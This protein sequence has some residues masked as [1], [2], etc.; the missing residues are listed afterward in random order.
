MPRR[1]HRREGNAL[2]AP[3]R[4]DSRFTGYGY[5]LIDWDDE[6][7]IKPSAVELGDDQGWFFWPPAG[8]PADA[9][10]PV[11]APNAKR[12]M[13]S[14][15][16]GG[17]LGEIVESAGGT[18]PGGVVIT[19]GEPN[20]DL[21]VLPYRDRSMDLD[22]RYEPMLVVDEKP[23][24]APPRESDT[25]IRIIGSK[26]GAPLAAG[27]PGIIASGTEEHSQENLF[28]PV[29]TT[30]IAHWRPGN[31]NW[32]S[33][34]VYD[35]DEKRVD[36]M[37]AG[38]L[39]T[40]MRVTTLLDEGDTIVPSPDYRPPTA[41]AWVGM[42]SVERGWPRTTIDR[43]GRG[44]TCHMSSPTQFGPPEETPPDV[45]LTG[46]DSGLTTVPLPGPAPPSPPGL[47][48]DT[49]PVLPPTKQLPLLAYHS[50]DGGGPLTAGGA[51]CQHQ[52]FTNIDE[53]NFRPG[54]LFTGSL[55]WAGDSYDAPLEFQ[56][57]EYPDP[58]DWP[59]LAKVHLVYDRK[60]THRWYGGDTSDEREGKGLWRW[61][62]EVPL[63]E[64]N[65][66]RIP[67]DRPPVDLPPEYGKPGAPAG[68]GG[69]GAA[70][71]PAG[72]PGGGAGAGDFEIPR[73]K[74]VWQ[75]GNAAARAQ[76][77]SIDRQG[78]EVDITP[79][80]YESWTDPKAEPGPGDD[81]GP[82]SEQER[83]RVRR[84]RR[85]GGMQGIDEENISGAGQQSQFGSPGRF[86]GLG[87]GS[88]DA[89]GTSGMQLGTR[90]SAEDDVL[91]GGSGDD[92]LSGTVPGTQIYT[93]REMAFPS[94]AGI[95]Q[96]SWIPIEDLRFESAPAEA[97]VR[98]DMRAP[99]V[100]RMQPYGF[101][102]EDPTKEWWDFTTLQGH[103]K[104]KTR[105]GTGPGGMGILPPELG[106]EDV[107]PG[108]PTLHNA[109]EISAS[110]MT[111]FRT[112][113]A[114]MR[115]YDPALGELEG[116]KLEVVEGGGV[117]LTG[118]GTDG[119]ETDSWTARINPTCGNLELT[120]SG[121]GGL[122]VGNASQIV[123]EA[124]E[125]LGFFPLKIGGTSGLVELIGLGPQQL[126]G[127]EDAD[128]WTV[129][130]L[131]KGATYADANSTDKQEGTYSLKVTIGGSYGGYPIEYQA[132][133][134][135]PIDASGA[136]NVTVWLKSTMAGAD[137]DIGLG[138]STGGSTKEY[139][140]TAQN[141]TGSWVQYSF[142][143][144]DWSAVD[145][146]NIDKI[147][148]KI[149]A[150]PGSTGDFYHDDLRAD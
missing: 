75:I 84:V 108:M 139:S 61:Y 121:T 10:V 56:A 76:N 97:Q 100:I 46:D 133:L 44:L 85:F 124:G 59:Y 57:E 67:P 142:P 4:I 140:G 116:H 82:D 15:L 71:G 54:H 149:T 29:G 58:P 35:I 101:T 129:I 72:G 127:H 106:M 12:P 77:A 103:E 24:P 92:V 20:E 16:R 31:P 122:D 114:F 118:V 117:K 51:M 135:A 45:I 112:C 145:K 47:V 141:V 87:Y 22:D 41:L 88:D 148:Y 5:R 73:G 143:L 115:N 70:G 104:S 69:P 2:F 14:W 3:N 93:H 9:T 18:L 98:Q 120:P 91:S 83:K 62:A 68:G 13:G 128:D 134:D 21:A 43:A 99:T 90:F 27:I 37:R 42:R 137:C 30:L 38:P 131:P 49:T 138:D 55:F 95:P 60:K 132:T 11:N 81:A 130:V 53:E 147:Y 34:L 102:S 63:G 136:T 19:G 74:A 6:P 111:F 25:R 52:L 119:T 125:S 123:Q 79:D 110:C 33:T 64:Y 113:L 8:L 26:P 17:C 23:I 78:G 40:T 66:P 89:F 94:F 48:G 36:P 1:D 96:R 144:A 39:D 150:N 109:R 32:F 146:A 28:L 50:T 65:P 80:T 7:V 86:G 107:I 105:S 126:D